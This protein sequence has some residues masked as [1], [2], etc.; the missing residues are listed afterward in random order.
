MSSLHI[1]VD[2]TGPEVTVTDSTSTDENEVMHWLADIIT[3]LVRAYEQG[4]LH[5]QRDCQAEHKTGSGPPHWGYRA[6]RESVE[7]TARHNVFATGRV[8]D[9]VTI[10][11]T[12]YSNE[13]SV[14]DGT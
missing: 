6:D 11:A 9:C 12:R 10:M 4:N 5:V 2:I 14:R 3:D 8:R 1:T 13:R 7:H